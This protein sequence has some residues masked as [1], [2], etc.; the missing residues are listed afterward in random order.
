MVVAASSKNMSQIGSSPDRGKP[1]AMADQ[2]HLL[3]KSTKIQPFMMENRIPGN[4]WKWPFC[5]FPPY[6]HPKIPQPYMVCKPLRNWGPNHHYPT[7]YT[8]RII[9]VS[10]NHG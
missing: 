3:G 8:W 4:S 6:G 2:L 5:H 7:T 1:P 9:P 10:N